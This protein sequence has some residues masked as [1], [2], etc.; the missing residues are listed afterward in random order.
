MGPTR[1]K[2]AAF[3]LLCISGAY[4]RDQFHGVRRDARA[5]KVLHLKGAES[6]RNELAT[7]RLPEL[8]WGSVYRVHQAA[9]MLRL[10]NFSPLRPRC[11]CQ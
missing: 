2:K 10:F 5:T 11:F 4:I 8:I 6:T 1:S 3:D 9:A 7:S